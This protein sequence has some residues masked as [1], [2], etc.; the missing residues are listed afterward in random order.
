L[1]QGVSR[2]QQE[3]ITSDSRGFALDLSR[4]AKIAVERFTQF[5]SEPTKTT[6][7]EVSSI[8]LSIP[9]ATS[10]KLPAAIPAPIAA[11][12]SITIQIIVM[13]SSRIALRASEFLS[14][15]IASVILRVSKLLAQ[16]NR[17]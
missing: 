11:T 2:K 10:S 6:I 9:K 4:V 15:A 17:Q 14:K 12:A 5:E 8:P 16:S 1:Q 3:K 7:A 13:I